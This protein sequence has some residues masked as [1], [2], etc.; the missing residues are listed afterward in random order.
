MKLRF[1]GSALFNE[2]VIVLG[3]AAVGTGYVILGYY[4]NNLTGYVIGGVIVTV[5]LAAAALKVYSVYCDLAANAVAEEELLRYARPKF[6]ELPE[7]D[8]AV[9]ECIVKA[10]SFNPSTSQE[11]TRLA[12]VG[13]ATGFML[14]EPITGR[15]VLHP[16]Y[17]H[18]VAKLVKE[19][20][21]SRGSAAP[22]SSAYP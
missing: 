21:T 15:F 18:V 8:K 11:R 16:N 10:K 4:G 22:A 17:A 19:W 2:N 5:A 1:L 20:R 3:I 9:L 7:A 12:A 14:P 6:A 13:E